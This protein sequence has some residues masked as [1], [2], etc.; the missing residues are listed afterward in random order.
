MRRVAWCC[1]VVAGVGLL[2]G[3]KDAGVVVDAGPAAVLSGAALRD[4]VYREA[5]YVVRRDHCIL[6]DGD[7]LPI[8]SY[9]YDK[10]GR[11]APMKAAAPSCDDQA[12]PLALLASLRAGLALVGAK[13]GADA[14]DATKIEADRGRADAAF[15]TVFGRP[16]VNAVTQTKSG[17]LLYAYDPAA[18]EAAFDALYVRPAGTVLGAS[19]KALYD[20]AARAPLARLARDLGALVKNK[21]KLGVEAKR[22]EQRAHK[23]D[24]GASTDALR[25][26]L[27]ALVDSTDDAARIDPALVGFVLRRQRDGTLPIVVSSLRRVLSDYDPASTKLLDG[28]P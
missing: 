24:D 19:A 18:L 10:K 28:R 22:W 17:Q 27:N 12:R 16:V 8:F 3:A 13:K 7:A 11:V 14:A 4:A 20:K 21:A 25:A 26:S 6:M 15:V 1:A 23:P 5:L 9:D 2:A